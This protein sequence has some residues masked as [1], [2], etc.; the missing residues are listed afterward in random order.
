MVLF[1]ISVIAA[2]NT[3]C[4]HSIVCTIDPISHFAKY[5]LL[6][7]DS[8][9]LGLPPTILSVMIKIQVTKEVSSFRPPVRK[10]IVQMKLMFSRGFALF[11][12]CCVLFVFV[13]VAPLQ[14]IQSHSTCWLCSYLFILPGRACTR[15]RGEVSFPLT[16]VK[17]IM[18]EQ[19]VFLYYSFSS[20]LATFHL[21]LQ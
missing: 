19:L 7:L 17:L 13:Q 9:L 3:F 15:P 4:H 2:L 1:D 8:T 5:P 18:N 16:H 12:S 21:K 20:P 10:W 14:R 11:K 6:W